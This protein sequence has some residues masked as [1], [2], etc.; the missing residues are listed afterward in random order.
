[1]NRSITIAVVITAAALLTACGSKPKPETPNRHKTAV[2]ATSDKGAAK[3]DTVSSRAVHDDGRAVDL[4]TIHFEYDS[5]ALTQ[6][7]RDILASNARYMQRQGKVT[8]Q[9]EGH[10][11]E[12]GTTEYNIALGERRARVARDY[13]IRLGVGGDRID[14]ISYGKERPVARGSSEDAWAQNRRGEFVSRAK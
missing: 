12:R 6:E 2:P 8:V 9:I 14:V 7:A 10:C 5:D 1:M 3:A 11:D 4:A 13:M